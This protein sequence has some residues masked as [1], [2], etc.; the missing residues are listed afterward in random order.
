MQ[1]EMPL[2]R[3][4][5]RLKFQSNE[6]LDIRTLFLPFDISVENQKVSHLLVGHVL[7][8][9]VFEQCKTDIVDLAD[10]VDSLEALGTPGLPELVSILREH[11]RQIAGE[12]GKG[13]NSKH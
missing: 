10:I 11:V 9:L 8:D 13:E 2:Q 7:E 1:V 6:P 4:L 12:A 5:E 3:Y